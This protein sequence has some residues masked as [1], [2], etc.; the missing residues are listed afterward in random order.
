MPLENIFNIFLT[1]GSIIYLGN[2]ALYKYF[3]NAP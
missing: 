2:K 3:F 1:F